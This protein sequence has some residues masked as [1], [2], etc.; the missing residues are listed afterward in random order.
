MASSGAG[1]T[2]WNS[3]PKLE[4]SLPLKPAQRTWSRRSA[5]PLERFVGLV[6]V[7]PR[8]IRRTIRDECRPPAV[9]RRQVWI[10][11]AVVDGD[12]WIR[13][14]R[15]RLRH[16]LHCDRPSV[17]SGSGVRPPRGGHRCAEGTASRL[18]LARLV[19]GHCLRSNT[20]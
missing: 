10:A 13:V 2:T 18:T 15:A 1:S 14:D 16:R 3:W 9:V 20:L 5:S 19:C 8:P 12:G 11:L 7:S 4:P 17:L 6:E